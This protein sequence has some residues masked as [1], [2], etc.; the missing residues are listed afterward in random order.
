MTHRIDHLL[1]ANMVPKGARVLD[2]GCGDG[3]LLLLLREMRGID[4]RGI[5]LSQ[6][7]VN[8]CVANGLY[9]VQGDADTD[10]RD[11]PDNAFDVVVLS[12]TIQAT[13]KPKDVLQHMLRIGKTAIVSFPNFGH[14]RVR[15]QVLCMGRMPTTRQLDTHWY[16]SENIHLCTVHDFVNLC[17]E[18]G[19][20]IETMLPLTSTDH[21]LPQVLGT[22]GANILAAQVVVSMKRG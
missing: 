8:A 16:E 5:E 4:G 9:V 12:Q 18:L 1:I 2:V 11:F 14:W 17:D 7:N 13:E 10:L 3:S 21:L 15:A 19:A 22:W 20:R 6:N